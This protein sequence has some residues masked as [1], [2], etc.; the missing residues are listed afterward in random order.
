MKQITIYK[1]E[2]AVDLSDDS[3]YLVLVKEWSGDDWVTHS[4]GIY[5]ESSA[6]VDVI[7]DLSHTSPVTIVAGPWFNCI[8]RNLGASLLRSEWGIV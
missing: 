2:E 5:R 8:A 4:T 6:L 7:V 1:Q 3:R